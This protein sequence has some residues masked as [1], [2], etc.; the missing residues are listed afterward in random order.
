LTLGINDEK[1]ATDTTSDFLRWTAERNIHLIVVL[2][3]NKN[4]LNARGHFGTECMNKAETTLSVTSCQNDS[5]ISIVDCVYSR[6]LPFE[7]F[8]FKIDE[9]GIPMS[10]EMP[11]KTTRSKL[12]KEPEK[13]TDDLHFSVLDLIYKANP[14]PKYHELWNAIKTGFNGKGI[15]FGESKAKEYIPYYSSQNWIKKDETNKVYRDIRMV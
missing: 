1:Q 2:H 15:F 8:A 9:W 11:V 6:D 7:S 10:F 14:E 12:S 3:Q 13:I 4:D 5:E